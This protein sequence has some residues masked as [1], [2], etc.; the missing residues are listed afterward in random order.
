M[1]FG[2]SDEFVQFRDELREFAEEVLTSP[3]G[4]RIAAWEGGHQGEE[5]H[6]LKTRLDERGWLKKSWPTEFGGEGASQWYQFILKNEL[7]Y[8]GLWKG[9]DTSSMIGPALQMF[10]NEQVK[11]EF[12]PKLWSGEYTFAIGYSEPNAG[13]DL[14]SLQTRA[15][16][17]GDEWVINGQ[18]IWTTGAHDSTHVWLAARTD[19]EAPKHRGISVI[20]VPL[21]TPGIT[22]R[23]LYTMGGERT[24]EVFYED[25][26]V[27]YHNL[28]G[29]EGRGWYIVATALDHERVGSGGHL[30]QAR[31]FDDLLSYMKE[32]RPELL[33]QERVR[34]Q[35]AE[36]KLDI[37]VMRAM[38]TINASIIANDR[39]PNAEASMLKITRSE[40]TYRYANNLVDALGRY[41]G[42]RQAAPGAPAGG[43]LEKQ[44][45]SSPPGIFAAGTNAV[46]RDIIARRGLGLPR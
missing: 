36:A 34:R 39:T 45:R 35:L 13:T 18:K 32:E 10:G 14:A 44:Y 16:H 5:M 27:P 26:R 4:D 41:G 28:V 24:N 43:H 31:S 3:L 2:W 7:M 23:P 17:E 8:R 33:K 20:I 40:G 15:E 9:I 12:L 25:V 29:E 19:P 1:E 37:H 42:L 38:A 22:V 6:E 30:G 46:Q 21:D 11:K